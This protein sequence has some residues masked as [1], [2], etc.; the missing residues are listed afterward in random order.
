MPFS[1]RLPR[2]N[3]EAWLPR[4]LLWQTFLL[5]ALLLVLGSGEPTLEQGFQ[6]L[7]EQHPGQ[8]AVHIGSMVY[9]EGCTP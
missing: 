7:S 8:V 6:A 9:H 5:F 1:P 2:L 3:S 4:T